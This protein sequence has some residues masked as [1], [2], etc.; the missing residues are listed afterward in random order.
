[1]TIMNPSIALKT[2]TPT[3][4]QTVQFNAFRLQWFTTN[5]SALNIK[6]EE[7]AVP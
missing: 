3:P 4:T 7:F 2:P 5:S 6:V 1:M